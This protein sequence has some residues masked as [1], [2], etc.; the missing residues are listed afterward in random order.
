MLVGVAAVCSIEG[1]LLAGVEGAGGLDVTEVFVV[2]VPVACVAVVAIE[3][4]STGA[5]QKHNFATAQPPPLHTITRKQGSL[6]H[7]HRSDNDIPV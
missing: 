3:A 6:T 2:V 4:S 7:T 1:T 5:N